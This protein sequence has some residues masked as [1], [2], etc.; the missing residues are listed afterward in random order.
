MTERDDP[1]TEAIFKALRELEGV[2]DKLMKRPEVAHLPSVLEEGELPECVARNGNLSIVFATDRRIINISASILGNSIRRVESFRYEAI[3][4]VRAETGLLST[5][6]SMLIEDGVKVIASDKDARQRFANHVRAKLSS[7]STPQSEAGTGD[8]TPPEFPM[9]RGGEEVEPPPKRRSWYRS[10]WLRAAVLI[11]VVI[12]IVAVLLTGGG[13]SVVVDRF[14][15][16]WELQGDELVLAIDTDLPDEGELS[17]S[18]SRWY[19][20]VGNDDAYSR[21]YFHEFEPVFRWRQ[22]RRIS[23]DATPWKADLAAH[24][25]RMAEIPDLAFEIDRIEDTVRIR[26]ILPINQD[27][28]RFGERNA[29]LSGEATFREGNRL[30]VE[31]E[32][33]FTLPLDGASEFVAAQAEQHAEQLR[34]S[35]ER[36]YAEWVVSWHRGVELSVAFIA[37]SLDDMETLNSL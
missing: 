13:E 2:D 5:G 32:D 16:E 3:R 19:Y 18:V 10:P 20:Q 31:A 21:D 17:V 33:F 25:A 36:Q 26:A 7:P 8:A 34:L 37:N 22:P 6:L 28:P 11:G 4:T 35:G 30:H 14:A 24:R 27:D 9:D 15:L 29:N 12:T 23:L 1:K